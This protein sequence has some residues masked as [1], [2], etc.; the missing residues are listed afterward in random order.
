MTFTAQLLDLR[1]GYVYFTSGD[2]FKLAD[3]YRL[4]DYDTGAADDDRSRP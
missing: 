4:V 3:A 2:A 1:G